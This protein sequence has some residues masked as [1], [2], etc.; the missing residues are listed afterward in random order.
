L[1]LLRRENM[2]SNMK[3]PGMS[4]ITGKVKQGEFSKAN[5]SSLYRPKM[6]KWGNEV[7]DAPGRHTLIQ[8]SASKSGSSQVQ[9]KINSLANET[10]YRGDRPGG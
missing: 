1:E 4:E 9:S 2:P 6:E 10:G 3:Y 5:E 8:K 7:P